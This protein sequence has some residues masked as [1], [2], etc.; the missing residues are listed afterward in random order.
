MLGKFRKVQPLKTVLLLIDFPNLICN[1]KLPPPE[2]LSFEKGFDRLVLKIAEDVGRIVGIFVFVPP[3]LASIW[4]DLFHKQGFFTIVCPKVRPKRGV[5][6]IET[7]DQTMI[8]FGKKIIPLIPSLTHLCIASGDV[9]FLP[10]SKIAAQNGLRTLIVTGSWDSLS[11][12]LRESAE[13]TRDGQ[14][15]LVYCFSPEE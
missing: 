3:N 11:K 6:E 5:E 12:E 4:C 15:K 9:D 7:V 13:R 2:Q 1:A 10:L 14:R 8:E